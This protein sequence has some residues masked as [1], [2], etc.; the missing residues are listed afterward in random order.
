MA[1]LG[2]PEVGGTPVPHD[3][4]TIGL[5]VGGTKISGA[6]VAPDGSVVRSAR[7][8]SP[9]TDSA[10]IV[11]SLADLVAELR[12]A[13]DRVAAVGV[14]AAGF[15]DRQRSTVLF[16]PNLAWRDEPLRA[17]LERRVEL[18]VVIENDANA[19]AWGEFRFG[20]GAEVDDLLMIT[21]GTGIGGGVVIDGKLMRGGFGIGAEVGHLR[22]VPDGQLCGCGNHGCWEQ[23][24]SGTAL[25]RSAR[26]EAGASLLA[27][28]LLERAAGD[29][30]RIDGPMISAL[31]AEG[32]PFAVAQLESLGGWLGA[33]VASLAAVLD[34]TLVVVGGGVSEAG[35][36]LLAPLRST[37]GR[38]LTGRGH[39]PMAEV[40]LATLGNRAGMLG[41]ADLAR[42][43]AA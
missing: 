19:A 43:P 32:D 1:A 42:T 25:V 2:T 23:Y 21:V 6:L 3:A 12:G 15:V 20:A 18:P 41:V 26:A 28:P 35:D 27:A 17:D 5:D 37:F 38:M 11:E 31:A 30:E 40:R 24:G 22:V 29:P 8:E 33:G 36:L 10:A 34:P 13:G 9:A 39:R 4:L 7:R 16:A 14:A